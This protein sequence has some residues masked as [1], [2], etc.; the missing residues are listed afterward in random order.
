VNPLR[1][2]T[3]PLRS[4]DTYRRWVHLVL[5]GALFVPFC[6]AVLVLATLLTGDGVGSAEDGFGPLGIVA[7][8][9]AGGLGAAT[10]WIPSVR[11]LQHQLARSLIRGPLAQDPVVPADSPRTRWRA[12]AWTALHLVVG[13]G[14]SIVTMVTLTEAALLALSAVVAEPTT[15]LSDGLW[16]LTDGPPAGAAR[17]AGPAVGAALIVATI[18][19]VALFGAGAARLAPVLL[20]PSTADRL[21]AAEARATQLTHRHQLATELHD[22][23]GHA[24]SV[25]ALQAGAAAR[26]LD[27]DPAFARRALEA[28]AQHARDAAGELDHVLGALREERPATAPQRTLDDLSQLVETARTAGADVSLDQRGPLDT[29]PPALSR[30]AYRVCQEGLTNALRHGIPDAPIGVSVV[31]QG[32][33]LR[34]AITNRAPR[35]AGT[36]TGGGHGLVGMQQRIAVLGGELESG[37]RGGTWRL[38]AAIPLETRR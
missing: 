24:L 13:F 37:V 31:V 15:M 9:A 25:V 20:G 28:I 21:A 34:L 36:R 33:D 8:V 5:G 27:Q 4:A 11:A 3:A 16:F 30:E 10:A 22:S 23:L 32:D 1:A 7:I 38:A 35:R 29:V 12:A 19:A 17:L 6:V 18:A 26:V 2:V 14:V